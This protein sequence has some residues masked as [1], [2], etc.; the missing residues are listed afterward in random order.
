M[1]LLLSWSLGT[2]K[3]KNAVQ[4]RLRAGKAKIENAGAH[5]Y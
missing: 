1:S 3:G 4:M 2:G 5:M